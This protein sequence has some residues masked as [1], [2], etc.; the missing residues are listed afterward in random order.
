MLVFWKA[1]LVLLAVPKTGTTAL[2]N[3]LSPVADTAILNPPGLKHC[4]VGKFR[5][6]LSGFF[7]QK[8]KRPLELVAVMREPIDWLGSWYRYRSR[9]ALAGQPNSTAGL[10]FD[11]FVDAYLG[12]SP[13]QFAKVGSQATFLEGGV[14]HLFR[15]DHQAGL[16]DFLEERLNQEIKLDRANV[17][18]GG[19]TS[20]SE[21]NEKRLRQDRAQ[22]FALWAAL[23]GRSAP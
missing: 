19:E 13:P 9:D 14:D 8:G 17:S 10:S 5:R 2:E 22:D 7:E 15:Y 23:S 4:T 3:C 12:K 21:T 11:E 18:P 20:L 16:I 1:R 6:E